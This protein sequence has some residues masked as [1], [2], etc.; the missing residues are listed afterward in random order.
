MPSCTTSL[1]SLKPSR[2]SPVAS[3]AAR[4]K[5][6]D[7]PPTI[8]WSPPSSCSALTAPASSAA[9]PPDAPPAASASGG[10]RRHGGERL[11]Q[12]G[13]LPARAFLDQARQQPHVRERHP[14]VRSGATRTWREQRGA[15]DGQDR[16]GG[17]DAGVLAD[18]GHDVERRGAAGRRRDGAR[19]E[20]RGVGGDTG[21]GWCVERDGVDRRRAADRVTQLAGVRPRPSRCRRRPPWTAEGS[22]RQVTEDAARV[23]ELVRRRAARRGRAR[24]WSRRRRP[25]SAADPD[26]S[27]SPQPSATRA[28][29]AASPPGATAARPSPRSDPRSRCR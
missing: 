10:G 20:R 7:S 24:R 21:D 14:G 26:P 8:C 29:P 5:P 27:R 17:H 13:Q 1:V 2:A 6:S 4:P 12:C 19:V 22:T 16:R 28:L 25:A 9:V 3:R 18:R 11:G 23:A 15:G